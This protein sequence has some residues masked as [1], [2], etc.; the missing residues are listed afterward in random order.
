MIDLR[1]LPI[2]PLEVADETPFLAQYFPNIFAK[3]LVPL[4]KYPTLHFKLFEGF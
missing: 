3:A 4:K 1:K 2:D